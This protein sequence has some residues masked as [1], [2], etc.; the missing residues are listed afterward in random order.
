MK[1]LFLS[2]LATTYSLLLL[3]QI[4]ASWNSVGPGGGGALFNPSINPANANEFYVACDM[5]G[6]YHTTDYGLSYSTSDFSK[7]Q[8]GSNGVIRFTNNANILYGIQDANDLAIPVKST[9]GGQTW[10]TLP[11]NPDEFEYVYYMYADYDNPNI[12]IMS[13]YNQLYITL[14]GGTSFTLV[15]N[16]N[17]SGSGILIGGAFFDGNNIYIG[18]NDGLYVSTNGGTSFSLR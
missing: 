6:Y 11:G 2:L 9:D 10:N 12:M 17:N 18:T 3:S 14:N 8:S 15:H 1:K 16:A 13:Y 7:I 4:P 5:S